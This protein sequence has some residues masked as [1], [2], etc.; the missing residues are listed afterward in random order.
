MVAYYGRLKTLWEELANHEQI[1]VYGCGGCTCDIGSK[2]ERRRE[3]E[4]VHQFLMGLDD[5]T[6]GT[7]RS[8][9]LACDPL[10]SLNRTYSIVVQEERVRTITRTKEERVEVVGL[11]AQVKGRGRGDARNKSQFCTHCNKQGHDAGSCFQLIGYPDWW[12]DRSKNEGKAI[13]KGK[14]QQH[15]S[16]GRG[17]GAALRANVAQASV[18]GMNSASIA[19]ADKAG[20]AGLTANQWQK[21]VE[22]LN[23]T[24]SDE[25]M[26]GKCKLTSWIIDT[27]ASNHMTG[28]LKEMSE[29]HNITACPV[30]LPNG[31][32]TNATK[33]G[34]IILEGG[35]KLKNVLYVP[36]LRCSLI[37]VSQLLDELN[38]VVQFTDKLCVMQDRISRML[39]GAGKRIDGLCYFC[40][41]QMVKVCKTNG[42]NQ[43]D[44]WH[45]RLGHPSFK[46]TRSIPEL[47]K[48]KCEEL[49]NKNCD[50]CFRAKQSRDV[51]PLSKHKANNIFELIHCD[52]WGPYKSQSSCGAYYFMTIVDDYSRGVWIYLLADKRE[53]SRML[54]N[55]FSLIK[56]QFDK[57]VKIFRSD[58]GTEFM[59]MKNYFFERGIIFQ[60]SC[61][62]TPQQNGRV[63][64]K[65]RHILNV[66][67]ALRFQGN[68][69]IE[70]WG[71]CVLAAG[72]LINRTP[73]A[74]LNRKT[75][76][77][78]LHGQTLSLQHL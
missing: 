32:R 56:T 41:A 19:D 14:S 70:F 6:Y 57:H 12:G 59:C 34:T 15:A 29:V 62:S 72:Y 44:L 33:E 37:S 68:L 52:L 74:V 53:V 63:E 24:D 18:S 67:R 66:A 64:R 48:N 46:I 58:N 75:P 22:L 13:G 50:I 55:F 16:G 23:K 4:K 76:Y 47:S 28:N 78:M 17:N 8:N 21:L 3:E 61:V 43:V 7:V 42:M 10:P 49:L 40:G 77:E 11:A 71:E 31:E 54:L 25:K 27:G 30:G 9:L 35:L 2:L 36:K 73:S 39:I 1:L 65:H 38:C 20:L 5:A 69:P 51:F 26:T 60:T 45:K